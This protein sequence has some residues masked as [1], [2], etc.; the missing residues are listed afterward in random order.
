[1][2]V[3]QEF[4]D[5]GS[6]VLRWG[7]VSSA[8]LWLGPQFYFAFV[9]PAARA[10]LEP[11]ALRALDLELT[12]RLSWWLRWGAALTWSLGFVLLFLT[13]YRTSLLLDVAA[14]D[15]FELEQ[16]LG[17]DG[18][19]TPRAWIP[20][21]LAL[22][23]AVVVYEL[24][25]RVLRSA[26]LELAVLGL[27]FAAAIGGSTFLA[28]ECHFAGRALF[29]QLGA[30]TA[31]FMATNV[32]L[33]IWPAERRLWIARRAGQAPDARD[34]ELAATR[35]RHNT[36]ATMPVVLLMLSNHHPSL[37]G[38]NLAP[39]PLVAAVLCAFGVLASLPF[40]PLGK[41]TPRP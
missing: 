17:P 24:L 28:G 23:G 7:H 20:G 30:M 34:L 19:P 32:W 36:L 41:L 8:I 40:T 22:I 16:F 18:R 31:S 35:A 14:I 3:F 5:P 27:Y 1:M 21:F 25:A 38:G 12:P 10:G 2:N 29:V 39:W 6:A 13:Y 15:A 11:A 9:A 26:K 4:L 37:Y 33:H